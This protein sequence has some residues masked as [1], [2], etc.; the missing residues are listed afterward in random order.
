MTLV[1]L[2]NSFVTVCVIVSIFATGFFIIETSSCATFCLFEILV[3]DN[4]KLRNKTI[5]QWFT[6][7]TNKEL[8]SFITDSEEKWKINILSVE[9]TYL[10]QNSNKTTWRKN[11]SI[12]SVFNAFESCIHAAAH[13]AILQSSFFRMYQVV[14]VV[15]PS[16]ESNNLKDCDS[17]L[18]WPITR[19]SVTCR[20]SI[21][22]LSVHS[23]C[24]QK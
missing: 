6:F 11:E 5:Y 15:R 2:V 18:L 1:Y 22:F 14:R 9:F 20:I 7:G 17:C 10:F 13:I 12:A 3:C 8:H 21:W 23:S 4:H 24:N 16:D 19:S